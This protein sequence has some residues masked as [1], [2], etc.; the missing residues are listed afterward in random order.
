MTVEDYCR[1]LRLWGLER[2]A[3]ETEKHARYARNNGPKLWVRKPQGLTDEQRVAELRAFARENRF[4]PP[5]T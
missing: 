4:D 2:V 1:Q 3:G 5:D